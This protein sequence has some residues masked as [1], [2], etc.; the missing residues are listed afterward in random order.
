MASI[1][2]TDD[3]ASVTPEVVGRTVVVYAGKRRPPWVWPAVPFA[4]FCETPRAHLDG[5]DTLVFVGLSQAMTPSSRTHMVWEVLF[6]K[7]ASV[8]RISV[9]EVLF[10]GAP[11]RA[12]FHFGFVGARYRDYTYSFIAESQWRTF[13]EGAREDDP[14]ALDEVLRWSRGVVSS[15]GRAHFD[16]LAIETIELGLAVHAEYAVAK[17]AAFEEET[18]ANAIVKRLAAFAAAACP[19]RAVP[20]PHR[21]WAARRPQIIATDLPVDRW[22]VSRLVGLADLTNGIAE[23]CAGG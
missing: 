16:A 2:L 15:S 13:V 8:R 10:R 12:W 6:N 3:L 18:S 22:L 21:L 9:D 5:A 7:L 23:G 11:W 19:R 17:T 20:A 4:T 1:L 14:F